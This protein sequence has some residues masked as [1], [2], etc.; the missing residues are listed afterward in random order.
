LVRYLFSASA[1]SF[2]GRSSR[3]S[4]GDSAGDSAG[5]DTVTGAGIFVDA[6]VFAGVFVGVFADTG[7]TVPGGGFSFGG[8]V[9][10]LTATAGLDSS[11]LD[12]KW[13]TSNNTKEIAI[14]PS[15]SHRYSYTACKMFFV[16]VAAVSS[17]PFSSYLGATPFIYM[18]VDIVFKI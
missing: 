10:A 9:V 3:V 8:G 4:A 18:F 11:R 14:A 13:N 12:T 1:T 7:A 5:A 2:S 15:T 6:G 16:C 17:S